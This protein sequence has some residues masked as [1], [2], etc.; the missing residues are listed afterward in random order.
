MT[1]DAAT[2]ATTATTTTMAVL[3]PTPTP[4]TWGTTAAA[5]AADISMLAEAIAG[6]AASPTLEPLST[7][8]A[9]PLPPGT[10]TAAP[11][12]DAPVSLDAP[13]A[14]PAIP[15][16]RPT[17]GR[18]APMSRPTVKM[19]ELL[20]NVVVPS[21]DAP[22]DREAHSNAASSAKVAAAPAPGSTV[23]FKPLADVMATRSAVVSAIGIV[24]CFLPVLSLGGLVMGLL[25]RRRI[26]HSDGAL[27]G[28]GSAKFGII[29]GAI[30]LVLG[31]TV[32]MVFLARR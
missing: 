10:P 11:I 18:G 1:T 19:V 23:H 17:E 28:E 7:T 2:A 15:Q 20:P 26:S 6:A 32:D 30:G 21:D 4:T 3:E 22:A 9:P 24:L 31:A 12:V 16:T 29:L 27:V 5:D 14:A 25:A 8:P 13:V